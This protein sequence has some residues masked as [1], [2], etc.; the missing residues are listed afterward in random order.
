VNLIDIAERVLGK[1]PTRVSE[2]VFRGARRIP[3][4]NRLLESEY[5]G[6]LE[7][8]PI[9]HPSGQ[10]AYVT[11]PDEPLTRD[12]IL[13]EVTALA[14]A[15]KDDGR[16]SRASGAVYH[17]GIEHVDL[18]SEVY[19]IH[20]QSNPLHI[21]IWPSGMKFEAEVV[22]M[23]ASMLGAGETDDEI[24]GTVTS[25]GTESIIM[26]MKAYRDRAGIHHPEMVVP[27]SAHVAFD[28]AAH[29][30]GYKQIKVP[31]GPDFRADPDGMARAVTRKTVVVAGSAPGFPHGVIDPIAD[32]AEMARER[33]VGF[34]TDACLGGFILPWAKRLGYEIP[35]FDFRLP[36]VTSMSADTHK[37][38]YAAKGTS[39]VLYRGRELRHH[40]FY[41]AADWPGGLYYSPTM[42]GSRPGALLATAWAAL[43]SMGEQGYLEATKAI[44]ETGKKVRT[45]IGALPELRV[46]GDPLWVIA[47]TSDVVSIY[48]VMAQ[49]GRRGWSLN[50]L[51]HPPAVHM[52]LTLRH[53]QPGVADAFLADLAWSVEEARKTGA[54]PQTGAAPIYG[55]AAT[56]PARGAVGDLLRRYIDKIYEVRARH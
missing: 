13:A 48:E 23:T 38:G 7:S 33:G 54:E 30:L 31:V 36:G 37:Y 14:D 44:L 35:P 19:A 6:I 40:Q 29:Y 16:Q 26:A 42:A 52:A 41:V 24:V 47:F 22:A 27:D 51:H 53:T 45:G 3:T 39:V 21:D 11:I 49:M 18:L 15:E 46:L 28:K 32:L 56:F 43:L 17:G 1:L 50:G 4:V 55:M 20:S 9:P 25:G 5:S 12:E 10:P 8:A 2:A 34:H